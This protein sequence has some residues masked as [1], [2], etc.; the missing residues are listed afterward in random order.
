MTCQ[1]LPKQKKINDERQ[2][3]TGNKS[4][5]ILNKGGPNFDS[6][7]SACNLVNYNNSIHRCNGRGAELI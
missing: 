2:F 3:S 1:R 5:H 6:A 7:Q 4:T